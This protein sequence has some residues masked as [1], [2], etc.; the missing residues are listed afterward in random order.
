MCCLWGDLICFSAGPCLSQSATPLHLDLTLRMGDQ[1][2]LVSKVQLQ[3]KAQGLNSAGENHLTINTA[4][5]RN[6]GRLYL[7]EASDKGGMCVSW[8]C[9][10]TTIFS[11]N[12]CMWRNCS[13]NTRG[14]KSAVFIL[15]SLVVL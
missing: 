6:P 14:F 10:G 15:G 5:N 11:Q 13:H 7:H 3:L 8:A 4:S 1:T 2:H 9:K 12:R